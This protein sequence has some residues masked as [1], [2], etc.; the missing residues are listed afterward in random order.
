MESTQ[1]G[2]HKS[3]AELIAEQVMEMFGCAIAKIETSTDLAARRPKYVTDCGCPLS[4]VGLDKY[5]ANYKE[6]LGDPEL[7]ASGQN[8]YLCGKITLLNY[9]KLQTTH[10]GEIAA[11]V[12][13]VRQSHVIQQM[14]SELENVQKQLS[15][16]V[17]K[18]L[19]RLKAGHAIDHSMVNS[20]HPISNTTPLES[21]DVL[22][23]QVKAAIEASDARRS[24][25]TG[26]PPRFN[27]AN[28]RSVSRNREAQSPTGQSIQEPKIGVALDRASSQEKS[29]VP[30]DTST[31]EQPRQGLFFEP[32][33]QNLGFF[34]PG[35]A[36]QSGI[37]SRV[38]SSHSSKSRTTGYT[39]NCK[40]ILCGDRRCGCL[41]RGIS[42]S[43][44][45]GCI[46]CT[47][48]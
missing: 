48:C 8:C 26:R 35:P 23:A 33:P 34:N 11:R 43:I 9:E 45:C 30:V 29:T 6:I 24:S 31:A 15:S 3:A 39:C 14:E 22:L 41:K 2:F 44:H 20:N 16:S 18:A 7:R 36:Q 5:L 38:I 17:S 27:Q 10:M 47:N 46:G 37:F 28:S 42:C 4:E 1:D 12:M 21:R 19:G 13:T 32:L 25:S 40:K